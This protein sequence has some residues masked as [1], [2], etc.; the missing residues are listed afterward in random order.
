MDSKVFTMFNVH[1]TKSLIS[2]FLHF[3]VIIY[4]SSDGAGVTDQDRVLHN[5]LVEAL[6]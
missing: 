3:I 4:R 1:L 2:M 5:F 6:D